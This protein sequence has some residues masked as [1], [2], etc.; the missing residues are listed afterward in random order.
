M[1]EIT[2]MSFYRER[3]RQ[4]KK[5]GWFNRL[6]EKKKEVGDGKP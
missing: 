1:D 6:L 2:M 4:Q 3:N 5:R